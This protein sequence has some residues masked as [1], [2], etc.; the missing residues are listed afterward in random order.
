MSASS[1]HPSRS[2]HRSRHRR[3]R[4]RVGGPYLQALG[5]RRQAL[6]DRIT[7]TSSYVKANW[8]PELDDVTVLLSDMPNQMRDGHD[9]R[10]T[11]D[12]RQRTIVLHRLPL[13]LGAEMED[14][15]EVQRQMT[16]EYCVLSAFAELTG[17]QPWEMHGHQI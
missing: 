15:D 6:I 16:I 4:S 3:L 17:R 8:A 12:Q 9:P 1:S 10:W 7:A 14:A 13:T 11:V 5:S 2:G